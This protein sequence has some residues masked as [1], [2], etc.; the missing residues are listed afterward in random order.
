[1][2]G[3]PFEIIKQK[4]KAMPE[5]GRDYYTLSLFDVYYVYNKYPVDGIFVGLS[6]TFHCSFI[7]IFAL[8]H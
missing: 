4:S 5:S 7:G 6:E 2:R 1:M 8:R 3:N